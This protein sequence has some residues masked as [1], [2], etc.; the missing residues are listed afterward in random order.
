MWN[1]GMG[2]VNLSCSRAFQGYMG[3]CLCK[4]ALSLSCLARSPPQGAK[5]TERFYSVIDTVC[6]HVPSDVLLVCWPGCMFPC[7]DVPVSTMKT[8][9]KNLNSKEF[10]AVCDVGVL[11]FDIFVGLRI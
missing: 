2:S 1:Q 4:S 6:V 5:D 8:C 7:I 3:T 11:P 9:L 10:L